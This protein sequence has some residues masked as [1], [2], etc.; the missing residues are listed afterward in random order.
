[1]AGLPVI[2][3]N[4]GM[5]AHAGS[6]AAGASD[7]TLTGALSLDCEVPGLSGALPVGRCSNA[8]R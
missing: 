4:A 5:L 6:V 1:M 3:A 7:T 8:C 2:F